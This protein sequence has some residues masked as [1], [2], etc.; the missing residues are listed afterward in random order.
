VMEAFN[1]VGQWQTT[2][3]GTGAPID[4]TADVVIDGN[5]EHMT[6]PADLMAALSKSAQAQR[7]YADLWVNFAYARTD[8]SID[9]CVV[10]DLAAKITKGGYTVLNL[11]ADLTQTD[12]FLVRVPEVSQ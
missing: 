2:E 10:N 4:S 12:S 1:A 8:N 3:A 5:S 9:A 11:I 6:G 7:R